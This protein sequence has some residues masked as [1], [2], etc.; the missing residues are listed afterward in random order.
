MPKLLQLLL[1]LLFSFHLLEAQQST[2]VYTSNNPNDRYFEFVLECPIKKCDILGRIIDTTL[3]VVP[4]K[5]KFTVV[6]YK[7]DLCIIRFTINAK[8]SKKLSKYGGAGD[9]MEYSYYLINKAQLDYKAKVRNI[10]QV[11][12]VV[13]SVMTPIKLRIVPFDFSKDISVGTTFGPK[14]Y[15]NKNR[16]TAFDVLVGFGLST[17]SI[18]TFSSKAKLKNPVEILAFS[19]SLGLVLE[20]GSAQVG[21]FGGY[22]LISNK[23]ER[24]YQWT[25]SGTPW[26]SFGI[27][28]SKF[29]FSM[30]R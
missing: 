16:T 19:P 1:P 21:V 5:S 2:S 20:F 29:S 12:I 9:V 22:D 18:D 7:N 24:L 23:H 17:V 8:K 28:F 11:D 30:K 3:L 6:E 15:F 10:S 14:F 13:G 26:F 4:P 27:G 25:Y